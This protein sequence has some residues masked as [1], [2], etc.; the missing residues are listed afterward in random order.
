MVNI[1]YYNSADFKER[2]NEWYAIWRSEV[3]GWGMEEWNSK[4]L[5]CRST[6]SP[7]S[8]RFFYPG[9]LHGQSKYVQYVPN[10]KSFTD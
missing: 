7:E 6:Q 3:R 8:C 5:R 1:F 10:Q 2:Q 9:F 4:L